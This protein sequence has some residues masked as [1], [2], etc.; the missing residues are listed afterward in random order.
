MLEST[1]KKYQE[2]IDLANPYR[3]K[4]TK[5]A[6]AEILNREHGL[7]M[8]ERT[9]RNI[10]I[11]MNEDFTYPA[12]INKKHIEGNSWQRDNRD[13]V[14]RHKHKIKK[15]SVEEFLANG[16][17]IDVLPSFEQAEPKAKMGYNA[18]F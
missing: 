2:V 9:F 17:K 6:I 4:K 16:G 15:Q 1:R 11:A 8:C 5:I 12:R 18:S 13:V 14:I 3:G 10:C 7:K